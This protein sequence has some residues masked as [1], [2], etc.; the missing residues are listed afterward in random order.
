MGNVTNENNQ[1]TSNDEM[2][3]N[4]EG[5]NKT[6]KQ[7]NIQNNRKARIQLRIYNEA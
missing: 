6:I 2:L 3:G 4:N 5:Q 7:S 1:T